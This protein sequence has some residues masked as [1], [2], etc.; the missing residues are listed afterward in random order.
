M[1]LLGMVLIRFHP[2]TSHYSPPVKLHILPKVLFVFPLKNQLNYRSDNALK[3][4]PSVSCIE[5]PV[6]HRNYKYG[7][8]FSNLSC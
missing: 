8:D 7:L 5:M 6:A 2:Q 1:G 4:H 3:M